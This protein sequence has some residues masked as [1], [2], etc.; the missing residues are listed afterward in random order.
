[1]EIDDMHDLAKAEFLFNPEGRYD[2]LARTHGGYWNYDVL[3]FC[4]IRNMYFPTPGVLSGIRH[5]LEHLLW[6]YGC[7]Q[8]AL[9]AKLAH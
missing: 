3:D 6:N 7:S 5:N 4:Y 1:M 2:S 9:N 8:S